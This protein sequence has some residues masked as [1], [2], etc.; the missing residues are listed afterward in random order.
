M[1]D[2][3]AQWLHLADGPREWL[4]PVWAIAALEGVA[5]GAAQ[6]GAIAARL[7]LGHALRALADDGE[8]VVVNASGLQA[9]GRI[10]AVGADY[11]VGRA[12][13]CHPVRGDSHR[14]A[15]SVGATRYDEVR[16]ASGCEIFSRVAAY[17]R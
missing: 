5:P 11:L 4:V 15:R 9:R 2:C 13:S 3:A 10:G 8:A 16:S 7:T 14:G 12:R 6:P 17:W 1:R